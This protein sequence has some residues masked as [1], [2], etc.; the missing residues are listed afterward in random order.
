[1]YSI[2]CVKICCYN[3]NYDIF[4]FSPLII[5]YLNFISAA[6]YSLFH[7]FHKIDVFLRIELQQEFFKTYNFSTFYR[8]NILCFI[9][10]IFNWSSFYHL[11]Q[12]LLSSHYLPLFPFS[13]LFL[14]IQ[15][16]FQ[17]VRIFFQLLQLHTFS[18]L[19]LF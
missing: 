8:C 4:L 2:H 9:T 1:M 5:Q 18:S 16:Y 15:H 11:S 10:F 7:S 3:S 12:C 19:V 6:L 17:Q 14:L 13:L